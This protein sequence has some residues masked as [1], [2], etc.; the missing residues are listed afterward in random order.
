[1]LRVLTFGQGIEGDTGVDHAGILAGPSRQQEQRGQGAQHRDEEAVG[2]F[3]LGRILLSLQNF[4]CLAL[5][6]GDLK[7]V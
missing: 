2:P 1:M 5:F 7:K 3:A 4:I 6:A